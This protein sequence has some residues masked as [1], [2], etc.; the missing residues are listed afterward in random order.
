[1]SRFIS[2]LIFS[3]L[4]AVAAIAQAP[5]VPSQAVDFAPRKQLIGPE[6][7]ITISAL[8]A[9]ELN[10]PWRVGISGDVSL[11]LVG[12]V[13]VA[14]LTVEEAERVIA[15]RMRKYYRDPQ[16]SVFISESR[17]EPI[18][19]IGAVEKPGTL[20]L[21]GN[22]TLFDALAE[23]GGPK[24]EATGVTLSRPVNQGEIP[25]PDKRSDGKVTTVDVPVSDVMTRRG[26]AASLEIR[27]YDVVNVT[28][29]KQQRLVTV[30]GEVVRPGVV[31]LV[32]QDS[33]SIAKI[34]AMA[35]GLSHTAAAKHTM[36]Y[37]VNDQGIKTSSAYVDLNKILAGK[38]K[39][40]ELSPGDIVIVPT[41]QIMSYV[42]AAGVSAVTTGV[43]LL[44]KI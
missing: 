25:W 5:K 22:T 21:K 11:P 18:T 20:Q 3:G 36:I 35:G 28:G 15:A 16:V 12:R 26:G 32:T 34:I 19:V 8:Y 44:G 38:V 33:V 6:D 30:A 24:T 23:A 31:E 2:A 10:K 13:H 41:S 4:C 9:D 17:S 7:T 14:G 39:D 40:I 1:M 42:Q 27:P 29:S 43:Y 37:H